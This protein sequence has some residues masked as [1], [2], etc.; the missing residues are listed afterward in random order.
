M[1]ASIEIIEAEALRLSAPERA[2]L[3][4]RL[5]AS[6]DVDPGVEDAWANEVARRNSEVENGK[7]TLVSGP[8]AVEKLKAAF[9]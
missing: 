8:D 5:I 4:E 2:R 7:A 9:K 1:A 3:I 6:L